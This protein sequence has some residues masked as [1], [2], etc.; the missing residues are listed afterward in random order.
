MAVYCD[1]EELK[2]EIP[3][4]E[5][6]Q[7]VND[8]N[9]TAE[10]IDLTDDEDTRA[11][12]ILAS[13]TDASGLIDS[14]LGNYEIEYTNPRLKKICKT[15][16]KYYL[17]ARRNVDMPAQLVAAYNNELEFLRDLQAG[18]VSLGLSNPAGRFVTN[19]TADDKVFTSQFLE[20]L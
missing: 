1:I 16:T 12:R 9:D 10:D 15:V 6:I 18:E 3:E 11:V 8:E 14:F 2:L 4:A 13:I 20:G 7:L 17:Y 5:L 19:K